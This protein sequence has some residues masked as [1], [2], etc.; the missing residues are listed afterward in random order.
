[1][2]SSARADPMSDRPSGTLELGVLV[3]QLAQLPDL[4]DLQELQDPPVRVRPLP[5]IKGRLADSHLSAHFADRLASLR[6]IQGEQYQF[7][8]KSRLLQGSL[9]LPCKDPGSTLLQF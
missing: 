2:T 5:D 1:M 9:S 8:G 4:Q 3:A 6:L 7:F